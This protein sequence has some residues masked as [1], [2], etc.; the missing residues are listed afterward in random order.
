MQRA[1]EVY[2]LA[3][4]HPVVANV[5]FWNDTNGKHVAAVAAS[6]P[7]EVV[8]AAKARGAALDLWDTA[9]ELL[10]ELEA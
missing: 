9:A 4:R 3:A 5:R 1:V 7:A 2:A 10:A 8:E 6:W